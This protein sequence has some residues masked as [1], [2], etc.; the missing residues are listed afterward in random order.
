MNNICFKNKKYNNRKLLKYG[1]KEIKDGFKYTEK[2]LDNQFE[3]I[4]EISKSGKIKTKVIEIEEK[5][6]YTLHLVE[7][8]EGTFVGKVREEYERILNAIEEKCFDSDVFKYEMTKRLINYAAEKYGDE[9]EYLWEKTPDNGVLRRKDTQKWYAAILTVKKNKFGFKSDEYVEV[10]N[11][12]VPPEDMEIILGNKNIYP[13][14]HMNK[15]HWISIILDNSV[16]FKD[17][18]RFTDNSYILA[19]K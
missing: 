17:I 18:C 10:V 4:I 8:A 14:Y 2:F 11:L 19:I 5:E 16:T 6:E 3:L 7:S 15:K 9:V 13:A 1:F 12:R